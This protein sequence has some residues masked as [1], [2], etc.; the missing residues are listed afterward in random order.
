MDA[1]FTLAPGQTETIAGA[2]TR[3]TFTGVTSD[4]RCPANAICI[5]GGDA[6]VRIDVWTAGR[7]ST[8][9][10]HTGNMQPVKASDLTIELIEVAPYPFSFT[11][12][13]PAAYRVT[14]QAKR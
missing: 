6:L 14:F 13:D 1:R 7:S 4:S 12:I 10:L 2:S 9:E 8:H 11:P 3:V 5:T